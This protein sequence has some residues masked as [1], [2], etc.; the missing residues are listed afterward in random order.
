MTCRKSLP[1]RKRVLSHTNVSRDPGPF[2]HT[3][4]HARQAEAE[5]TDDAERV[6]DGGNEQ[7]SERQVHEEGVAGV[8]QRLVDADGEKDAEVAERPERGR[9]ERHDEVRVRRA[10]VPRDEVAP[11]QQV[12]RWGGEIVLSDS[13][14][15]QREHDKGAVLRVGFPYQTKKRTT[16][17]AAPT[18]FNLERRLLILSFSI[19]L[20]EFTRGC[21]TTHP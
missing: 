18:V 17:A 12:V 9:Q 13:W 5:L 4:A 20:V 1:P 19:F 11:S 7:V 14:L 3:H 10:R 21:R 8:A 6:S 2:S 16:C 15:D